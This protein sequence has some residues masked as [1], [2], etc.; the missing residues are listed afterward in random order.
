MLRPMAFPKLYTACG[1]AVPIFTCSNT[2]P[3]VKSYN[4]YITELYSWTILPPRNTRKSLVTRGPCRSPEFVPPLCVLSLALRLDLFL[5]LL[6]SFFGLPPGAFLPAL[7]DYFDVAL[8]VSPFA[9]AKVLAVLVRGHA[10]EDE[11]S[12]CPVRGLL[13]MT[14]CRVSVFSPSKSATWVYGSIRA[15]IESGL[16]RQGKARQGKAKTNR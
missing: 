7:V 5:M 13:D 4:Q 12:G 11:E 15:Q 8:H 1:Y 6:S 2:S 3:P 14:C 10:T 16:R 9:S